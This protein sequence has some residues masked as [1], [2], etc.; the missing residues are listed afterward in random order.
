MAKKRYIG[1]APEIA[2]VRTATVGGTIEVGDLF[3]LTIGAVTLVIAA[4]TTV[5]ADVAQLIADTWQNLD[6]SAY[7]Q[8]AEITAQA[9]GATVSFEAV[10]PGKPF[11]LT[12][13]T[14]ES[15]GDPADAQTFSIADT[16]TNSG[17]NDISC[18]DNWSG[19]SLPINGDDIIIDEDSPSLLWNLSALSAVVAASVRITCGRNTKI[20]LFQEDDNDYPQYRPAAFA[21]QAASWF[22]E[23]DSTYVNIDVCDATATSVVVQRT[24]QR[25]EPTRAA[26]CIQGENNA[27]SLTLL[28]GDVALSMADDELAKFP[29]VFESYLTNVDSDATL[30]CGPSCTLGAFVQNGGTAV[31]WTAIASG[32]TQ[33]AGQHTHYAGKITGPI[34]YGGRLNYNSTTA[35]DGAAR[36]SGGHLDFGADPRPKTVDNPIEFYGG[37]ISD[38]F[39]VVNTA[40]SFVIDMNEN[41]MLANIRVG[42]NRRVTF[43]A[44][45]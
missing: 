44:V 28:K 12:V 29:S 30:Y 40:G 14:T 36:V 26:L 31:T 10:T 33:R 37:Q 11:T 8:F 19:E 5:A 13:A 41:A 22:I 38:P 6:S 2:M 39:N 27:H 34:C 7:P 21:V 43:A 16:V 42:A 17:P 24:G 3:R 32:F 9:N 35:M 1:A 15:N 45:A 20:G 25:A 18:V 23:C 4:A